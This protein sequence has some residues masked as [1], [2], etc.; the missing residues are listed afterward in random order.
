MAEVVLMQ[1]K[2]QHYISNQFVDIVTMNQQML[3]VFR[4][5]Q[6]I[7]NK[8]SQRFDRNTGWEN[9]EMAKNLTMMVEIPNFHNY[10][11]IT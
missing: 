9:P 6:E 5:S 1:N 7:N 10:C 8:A 11:Q 3:Q 4:L 2:S